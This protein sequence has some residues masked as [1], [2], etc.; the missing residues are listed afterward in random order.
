MM[1]VPTKSLVFD[2]LGD[3]A[4]GHGAFDFSERI[5][6]T[7]A[8]VVTQLCAMDAERVLLWL[9]TVGP[10]TSFLISTR[11]NMTAADGLALPAGGNQLF[12][13]VAH[14]PLCQLRWH[15]LQGGLAGDAGVLEVFKRR[16]PPLLRPLDRQRQ[17]ITRPRDALMRGVARSCK[18]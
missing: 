3:T 14:G 12:T 2:W 7:P 15:A 9:W 4:S 5:V 16:E 10:G 11:S 6:A 17:Y 18:R 1:Q 8:G 13:W